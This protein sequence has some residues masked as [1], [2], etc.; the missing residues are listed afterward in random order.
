MVYSSIPLQQPVILRRVLDYVGPGHWCFVA[1]VSSLWRDLYSEVP[2]RELQAIARFGETKTI[3]CVPQMTISSAVFE[4]PARV[5]FAAAH[6]LD[7]TSV[8]CQHA[9]GMH[10]DVAPLE[11]AH[12]LGM[13]Y[14]NP[15]MEG[16]ARCNQLA[17]VQFL[18]AQGCKLD[19]TL[20]DLAA[21]RGHTAMC[22]YLHAERCP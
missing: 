4:T 10:A 18:H 16:A 19:R 22:A 5:R 9:A 15:V 14:K 21:G 1:E 17:V 7:C 3:T 2:S 13:P 20:F 12:G 8:P 11:A 6:G